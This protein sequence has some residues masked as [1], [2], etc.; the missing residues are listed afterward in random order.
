MDSL[1]ANIDVSNCYN[2]AEID[3]VVANQTYAMLRYAV[4]RHTILYDTMLCD[5]VLY[6]TVTSITITIDMLCKY[7]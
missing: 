5:T 1:I 3:T 7:C 2:N 6:Y 4:L